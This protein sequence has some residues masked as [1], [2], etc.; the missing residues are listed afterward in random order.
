MGELKAAATESGQ[1]EAV[2]IVVSPEETAEERAA[3]VDAIIG[4][5]ADIPFSSEDL[6][7]E[8]REEREREERRWK[9]WGA[10]T[11]SP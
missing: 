11:P 1:S 10:S 8:K 7:R 4:K 5:Y 2:T 3:R 6:M 9:A